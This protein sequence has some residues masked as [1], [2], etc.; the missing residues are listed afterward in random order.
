MILYAAASRRRLGEIIGGDD[1]RAHVQE[2]DAWM[3]AQQ[4][5]N[6]ARMAN[7]FAAEVRRSTSAP[8]NDPG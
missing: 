5:R 1:G 8:E 4:I 7:V 2:A 3:T 6:P